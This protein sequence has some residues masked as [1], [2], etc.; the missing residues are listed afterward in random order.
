MLSL[1]LATF[2]CIIQ[3]GQVC[4]T[5]PIS[6]ENMSFLRFLIGESLSIKSQLE[7]CQFKFLKDVNVQLLLQIEVDRNRV[8]PWWFPAASAK[9]ENNLAR[10]QRSLH[11]H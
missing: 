6:R 5:R 11:C 8:R 10:H 9:K 4:F 1:S 3:S 2:K 7:P